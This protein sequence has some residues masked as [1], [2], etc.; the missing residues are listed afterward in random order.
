M[1]YYSMMKT[2]IELDSALLQAAK[3]RALDTNT[4]L[5]N[6][7]ELALRQL[8]RPV[9]SVSP[10]IRTITFGKTTSSWPLNDA[11]MRAHAYPEQS[12]EYLNKRLGA[13]PSRKVGSK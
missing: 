7:L 11:K 3:Q 9:E 12:E 4:S 2:T 6:V 5:K 10:P 1:G 13:A 8:L